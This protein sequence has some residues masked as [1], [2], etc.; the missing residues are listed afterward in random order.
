MH[1]LRYGR[2]INHTEITP[3]RHAQV[4]D[5]TV[6]LTNIYDKTAVDEYYNRN[7]GVGSNRWPK[8]NND[9]PK[10]VAPRGRVRYGASVPR[11]YDCKWLRTRGGCFGHRKNM[12]MIKDKSVFIRITNTVI[13]ACT[14]DSA[15]ADHRRRRETIT[16]LC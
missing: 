10:L 1:P 11:D 7:R 3:D 9:S 13:L 4:A 5:I 15:K 14:A 12:Q 2:R 6:H 16:V 8:K